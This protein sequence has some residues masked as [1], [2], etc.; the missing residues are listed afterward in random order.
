MYKYIVVYTVLLKKEMATHSSILA[1][2]KR[3]LVG[4][5]SWGHEELDTTEHTS[6]FTFISNGH[7]AYIH[8]KRV[9][10]ETKLVVSLLSKN[11]VLFW[12]KNCNSSE[13]KDTLKSM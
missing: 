7:T 11:Y 4:Y 12:V 6:N 8:Y 9:Y 13:Q 3:S 1:W 5:S 2:K 10:R